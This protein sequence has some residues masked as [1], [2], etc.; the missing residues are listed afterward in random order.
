MNL[1]K[2]K[3]TCLLNPTTYFSRLH[4]LN[5]KSWDT[6][7]LIILRHFINPMIN[8]SAH[9]LTAHELIMEIWVAVW[10]FCCSEVWSVRIDVV[11]LV[12][13][14]QCGLMFR[15]CVPAVPRYH[16]TVTGPPPPHHPL[17]PPPPPAPPPPP[18]PPLIIPCRC[19]APG[20]RSIRWPQI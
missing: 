18:R 8:Q 6:V 1:F 20:P 14:H 10:C 11:M 7:F 15:V 12:L 3:P 5:L 2:T 9:E 4:H 16:S 13:F 19:S 17:P